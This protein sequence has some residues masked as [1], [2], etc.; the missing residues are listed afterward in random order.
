MKHITAKT[1][2]FHVA[3]STQLFSLF[4]L[5][6]STVALWIIEI[7]LALDLSLETQRKFSGFT[8][9]TST[10][11]YVA[12]L[13]DIAPTIVIKWLVLSMALTAALLLIKR[14]RTHGKSYVVGSAVFIVFCLLAAALA[15]DIVRTNLS[16][17]AAT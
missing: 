17:L 13:T 4:A 2:L 9:T 10:N 5:G 11:E 16:T 1:V 14:V 12:S 8:D 3:K 6:L 15:H 7:F